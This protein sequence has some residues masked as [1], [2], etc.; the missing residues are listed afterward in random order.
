MSELILK[1]RLN[2]YIQ[3]LRDELEKCE[4]AKQKQVY[5]KTPN[6]VIFVLNKTFCTRDHMAICLREIY[7]KPR[8]LESDGLCGPFS[9]QGT[10]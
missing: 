10:E 3:L 5:Y 7:M 4:D 6:C 8:D 9:L 1:A 2:L